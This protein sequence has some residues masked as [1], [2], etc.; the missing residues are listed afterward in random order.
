MARGLALRRWSSAG[1]YR[2]A[3]LARL[4]A[5]DGRRFEALNGE[6]FDP[7]VRARVLDRVAASLGPVD[8]LIYSVA[9]PRRTDPRT[10]TVSHS[11]VKPIGAAY[12]ASSVAF[13]G[14]AVLRDV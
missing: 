11:A 7:A 2:T 9:A 5:D 1:W 6:C 4:A 8:V 3:A 10:G 14:G 12:S 13:S